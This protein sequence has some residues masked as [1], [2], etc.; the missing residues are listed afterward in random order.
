MLGQLLPQGQLAAKA[1]AATTCIQL[2]VAPTHQLDG[3]LVSGSL[4][5][6]IPALLACAA[7]HQQGP[8]T[9]LGALDLQCGCGAAVEQ[10]HVQHQQHL[11][12]LLLLH[13]SDSTPFFK[14]PNECMG[15]PK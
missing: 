2:M 3:I 4:Y 1:V 8:N 14:L 11:L 12:L 10:L 15:R 6:C 7:H 9:L 5:V 13:C